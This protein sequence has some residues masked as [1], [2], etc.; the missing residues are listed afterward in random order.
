[1]TLTVKTHWHRPDFTLSVDMAFPSQGIT[2]LFGRSGCGKTSLFRVISGLERVADTYVSFQ[3]RAWQ[4]NAQ[5]VPLHHRRIGFV[6][7][8]ASLL[9]HLSVRDNLLYGYRR[10]PEAER[11]LQLD[12]VTDLLA[13]KPLLNRRIHEISG[14]QRQRVALGRAL[15]SS[16]Q[17]LLLDEPFAALDSATKNEI[18]PYVREMTNRWAIPVILVSHDVRE[19]EQ[20]ADYVA[21]ME[22]GTVRSLDTLEQTMRDPHS[23]LF[24]EV[25][26]ATVLSGNVTAQSGPRIFQISDGT[27]TWLTHSPRPLTINESVR[28]QVKASDVAIALQPLQGISIRNQFVAV[29]ESLGNEQGGPV[30]LKLEN[31]HLIFADISEEAVDELRL[32]VGQSVIALIKSA[33]ILV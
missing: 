27:C 6:F 20:L 26:P 5:F 17:L 2:A 31:G 7:Q 18:I 16:P 28:C 23:P 13:I 32:K 19:V 12:E 1:M 4:S 30:L 15:L 25:E 24:R 11:R 29:V 3:G 22:E 9:E 14:G 8:E 21:L 10:T 33:A